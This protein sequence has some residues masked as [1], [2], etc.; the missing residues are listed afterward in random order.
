MAEDVDWEVAVEAAA[1][2]YNRE[3][4]AE[5][6]RIEDEAR[7]LGFTVLKKAP[8]DASGVRRKHSEIIL[9]F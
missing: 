5:I 1:I 2:D 4:D 9:E 8:K 3:R 7:A 6:K